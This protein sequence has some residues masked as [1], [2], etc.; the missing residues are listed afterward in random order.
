MKKISKIFFSVQESNVGIICRYLDTYGVY[1][2]IFKLFYFSLGLN[3][4]SYV[5]LFK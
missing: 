3:I 2:Y 1:L 4:N 5:N